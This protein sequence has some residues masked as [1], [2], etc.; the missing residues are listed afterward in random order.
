V[1]PDDDL[2]AAFINGKWQFARKDGSAY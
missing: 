2:Q 1:Y